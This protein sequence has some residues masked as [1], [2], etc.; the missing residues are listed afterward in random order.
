MIHIDLIK[1]SQH[2][3]FLMNTLSYIKFLV[4]FDVAKN[5]AQILSG[6]TMMQC[7]FL[8]YSM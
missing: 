4:Q 6:N 3:Y 2:F 7:I 1:S 8:K 5:S